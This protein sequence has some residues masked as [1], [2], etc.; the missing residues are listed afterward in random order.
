MTALAPVAGRPIPD[1]LNQSLRS[2]MLVP[3]WI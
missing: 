3:T 2:D 1:W